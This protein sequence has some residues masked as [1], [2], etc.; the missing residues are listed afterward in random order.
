MSLI[1]GTGGG[2]GGAGAPGGALGSFYSH[3]LDQSLKFDDGD[4]QVLKRTPAS[5]GDRQKFTLK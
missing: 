2:L 1:Q 5:A 4:A 3:L